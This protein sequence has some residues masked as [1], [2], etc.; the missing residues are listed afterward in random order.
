MSDTETNPPLSDDVLPDAQNA[1]PA[2]DDALPD[3]QSTPPAPDDAL[4]A[5]SVSDTQ[6]IK[7]GKNRRVGVLISALIIVAALALGGFAGYTQAIGARVS[8]Q[9]TSEAKLVV[10]Q[11]TLAEQDFA[12]KNYDAARQ[13]LEYIIERDPNYPGAADLLTKLLV[14]MAVTPSLTPTPIPSSTPTP[15][16][17]SQETIFAQAQA[18][19]KSSDWTN[20][21]ASLDALRK[22][23]PTYKTVQVDG[24]YYSALRNRG[25]DQI[26]GNRA[27]AQTTNLEG[28]IYDLT[29]AERFG[30]LDGLADGMRTWAR[31]YIIGAS[32]W[33]LDWAQAVNYFGQVADQ[34]PNLRDASNFT[35]LQRYHD[36][37]LKYGDLQAS[38]SRLKD[39]CLAL[40]SWGKARDIGG[41]DNEYTQKFFDLNLQ[42]NPPTATPEPTTGP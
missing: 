15:D 24:M 40:V 8:V 42:C 32:F 10:E 11:F 30:P 39:R 35:A 3:T 7:K 27:Y 21:M 16:L 1:T 9:Q 2:P 41:L 34:A 19:L 26:M 14:Q 18:Q 36:A 13:R 6:P 12:G 28:G 31:Y 22:A 33:E 5:D 38:A 25:M 20:A 37:L 23:D 29:L 17:R 4:P